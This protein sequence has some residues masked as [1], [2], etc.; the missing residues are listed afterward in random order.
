LLSA[1]PAAAQLQI[2][3]PPINYGK[4]AHADAVGK[5]QS[6]VDKQQ[7]NL[8]YD[9]RY[10]YLP[11]LLRE[12]KISPKSQVLVFTK[13]SFQR[14]LIS[15]SSPRAIYFNDDS[16]V[17]SVRGGKVFELSSI[18]P[19]LGAIFYTLDQSREAQPHLVRQ[20][21]DCTQCH[22]SPMTDGIAGSIVR[23]VYPGRTGDPI[24]TAG[25]FRTSY[26]SPLS[27]RWGGWYVTGTHGQQ[28]HMGNVTL[29]G[30][31]PARLD[32]EKG[33]NVTD[34][35][36]RFDTSQYLTAQSDIV[37]LMVLE[38][39]VYTH[40]QFTAAAYRGKMARVEQEAINKL[41]N[42]PAGSPIESVERRYQWAADD[43]LKCLL[44]SDESQL[45]DKVRGTSGFAEY[46]TALG[47]KDRSGRS[48][49]DFDL[50]IRLFKYRC[51][52]LIYSDAFQQLHEPVKN[53][54]YKRLWRVL[55]SQEQSKEF[56][57]L[58]KSE[59]RII[60]EILTDT[61]PGLPDYWRTKTP[62]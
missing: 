36:G 50:N 58:D 11:S 56:A 1:R 23:S 22:A 40:N 12:L 25:T 60:Y 35:S 26:Q 34:L 18:D 10:G 2:D 20:Q 39:Q 48:L 37:A 8:D 51:S 31:N 61:L 41:D 16:Y 59:R 4:A 55:T 62:L 45:T 14:D 5:L 57:Y 47:P 38:H 43:V 15:P 33:A 24:L 30:S 3:A 52:Y 27:E 49:R 54:V 29:R 7:I 53:L 13:T 21:E 44:F 32:R 19:Q 28:R 17:G 6:R 46:F 42:K 9:T